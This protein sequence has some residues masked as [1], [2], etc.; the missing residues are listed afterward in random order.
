MSDYLLTQPVDFAR[1][2]EEV[3]QVWAAYSAGR[4]TRA[5]ITFSMNPR[6]IVQNAE[7]NVWG[8]DW[9]DYFTGHWQKRH[10][11]A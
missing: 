6:M 9:Q 5:P 10:D 2:N 4:P 11:C 8:Y 3:A 7:L 1:H